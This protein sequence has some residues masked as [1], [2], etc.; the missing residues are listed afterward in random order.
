MSPPSVAWTP[1]SPSAC[2][3]LREPDREPGHEFELHAEAHERLEVRGGVRRRVVELR[4]DQVDVPVDEDVLPGHEDVVEHDGGV[5]LVEAG[6][7]RIVEDARC[8]R[9]EG[10]PR[11]EA[12]PL[13]VHRHDER[14]RVVLVAGHQ[15][16]DVG[17]E[18]PVGH[19]RRCGDRVGAPDDDPRRGLAHH[20]RVQE[21][22]RVPMG[23]A[24]S[25][26]LGRHDRVGHVEI[27]VTGAGIEVLHVVAE[28]RAGAV[29]EVPPCRKGRENA[30][31][32]VGG[33]AHEPERR[34]G[35]EPMRA[36][37]G[38]EV[39][40]GARDEPHVAVPRARRRV[41]ERQRR[42]ALRGLR[43]V[44][45]L[46]DPPDGLD[47]RGVLGD[48]V[49]ALAVEVHRPPVS[50]ARDVRVTAAHRPLTLPQA[51]GNDKRRRPAGRGD[52]DGRFAAAGRRGAGAPPA[53]ARLW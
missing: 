48:V 8:H 40:R 36:P 43:A 50:E 35:P 5:D 47:E 41:G 49:D 23:G 12:Q 11:V 29:E 46:G 38:A 9:R 3:D 37:P 27:F 2:L 14:D 33:A 22:L 4:V 32:V 16:G 42:I 39:L 20:A 52:C 19:R 6:R 51:A 10:A 13:G 53:E 25:I 44:V 15:R 1:A 45:G 31:D 30:R 24:R 21:R 28:A 17:H 18:E 26:H 34:L 7:E